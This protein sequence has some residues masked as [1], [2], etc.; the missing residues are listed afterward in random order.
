[1]QRGDDEAAGARV[2]LERAGPAK[3]LEQPSVWNPV[4]ASRA[5]LGPLP[6]RGV[7]GARG[8]QRLLRVL[9]TWTWGLGRGDGPAIAW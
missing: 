2:A 1:M 7:V 4:A 3:P 6:A 5:L 9:A 8:L